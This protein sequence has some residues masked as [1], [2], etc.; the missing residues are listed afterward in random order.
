MP[1]VTIRIPPT[2]HAR[3]QRLAAV[4][5]RSLGEVVDVALAHYE[6]ER[7]LAA[8]NE[9]MNRLQADPAAWADWQAEVESLEGTMADG[10]DDWPYEGVEELPA[11][12]SDGP[13]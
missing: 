2:A 11:D 7:M 8:Y 12:T 13:H 10:L 9:A 6:R 3:A 4:A 5:G 1:T